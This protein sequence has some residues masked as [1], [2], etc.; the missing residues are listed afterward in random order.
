MGMGFFAP[1]VSLAAPFVSV[2]W[3]L[4]NK[5]LPWDAAVSAGTERVKTTLADKIVLTCF[6]LFLASGYF[7]T[8]RIAYLYRAPD[9]A[10]LEE[11]VLA[12]YYE[13]IRPRLVRTLSPEAPL[14]PENAEEAIKT[15]RDVQEKIQY[16][17]DEILLMKD[18]VLQRFEKMPE[19]GW[20]HIRQEQAE[21]FFNRLDRFL[22]SEGMRIGL[23]ENILGYFRS[24]ERNGYEIVDGR[25][26]FRDAEMNRQYDNY[27][28]Q[29]QSFLLSGVQDD[30]TAD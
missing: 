12:P 10:G 23:F 4:K 21:I 14:T 24:P 8:A 1:Y 7:M 19:S 22:F 20:R 29:L 13:E 2:V 30:E 26:V 5:V 27:M 25:P 16:Q 3:F 28:I 15:L 9:Y 18:A 11:K 17:K 6:L